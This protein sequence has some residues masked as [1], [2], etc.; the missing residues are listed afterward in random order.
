M[1][2]NMNICILISGILLEHNILVYW[3]RS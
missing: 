3:T 1:V 2:C